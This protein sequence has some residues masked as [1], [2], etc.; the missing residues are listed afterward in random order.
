MRFE[1][2]FDANRMARVD[3][4]YVRPRQSASFELL[5]D[6][7]TYR[8]AVNE[9]IAGGGDGYFMFK[10]LTSS[11]I[12]T[13]E[14]EILGDY[15]KAMA[16]NQPGLVVSLEDRIRQMPSTVRL[17]L[18]ILCSLN[19]PTDAFG[20]EHCDHTRHAVDLVNNKVDGLFDSILPD[21]AIVIHEL[22]LSCL[23]KTAALE[24][25]A[26]L[27]QQLPLVVAVIGP[28][29]S[30]AV[31][32]LSGPLFDDYFR[33]NADLRALLISPLSTD[34]SLQDETLYPNLVRVTSSEFHY[35]QAMMEVMR[36]FNW[37]RVG[38]LNDDSRW[39]NSTADVLI[40]NFH[41]LGDQRVLNLGSTSFSVA[42]FETGAMSAPPAVEPLRSC[43]HL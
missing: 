6:V 25:F 36:S 8:V 18:G 27:R 13:P 28:D 19:G 17:E 10:D 33:N 5:S 26:T 11:A 31:E 41:G 23:N 1:W 42:D 32:A 35:V 3:S 9:Y 24:S 4:I 16:S 34:V 39:A 30:D 12:G 14:Y 7:A 40:R 21:A 20:R 43:S 15:V 2:H 37:N 29:C 22:P 38:V